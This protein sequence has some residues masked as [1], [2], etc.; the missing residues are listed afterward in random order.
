[1][2][3]QGAMIRIRGNASLSQSNE[4]IIFVD[5]VRMN[6]GS[7]FAG[8]G[9]G[10]GGATTRLDDIDPNTIE[11]IEVLK[12]AA[13]ATLYG[14]EASNGVIQIITKQGSAVPTRWNFAVQ[15]DAIQFPDRVA[16]VA[17]FARTQ[18]QADTLSQ[19]WNRTIVPFQ[20]FEENVFRDF[21]TETGANTVASGNVTGGTSAFTYFA[22][23]RFANE[24]GPFG[25][26]NYGPATDEVRR[27]QA[28]ANLTMKPFRGFRL[29]VRNNYVN[30]RNTTPESNNNIYGV[31]S[32]A[33]MA[34]PELANCRLSAIESRGKCT[35]AGNPFGNQAFMTVR[36]AMGQINAAS[37]TRYFGSV[38]LS[39]QQTD[40]LNYSAT[41][42]YDNAS[43]REFGFAGFGYNVDQFT[44]QTPNGRRDVYTS[45]SRVATLD[46][47]IAYNRTFGDISTSTVGGLQVFNNRFASSSGGA[48]D[49]PGPGIEVVGA[50]AAAI[51]AGESF[52]TTV[53][54]GYFGQTQIGWREWMFGT[55]GGRYDFASAFGANAGGVFYPKV[56]VSIV[57]SDRKSWN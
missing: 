54:G 6:N 3:G 41:L 21:L 10:G 40:H 46:S 1:M 16:P 5:G 45:T 56:S 22:S 43:S 55:V 53:N 35:G 51:A 17:G 15:Q 13:A 29:S 38:D 44:A 57:P 37:S 18:G 32:L 2:S 4:P 47:K 39:Y 27:A 12:G 9:T 50:G 14:T 11:R 19:I 36:E 20:V 31:N 48:Q 8:I 33:F 7:S 52:L 28:T 26:T 34:R 30:T 25:G 42:G 23:G 49:F 24:N